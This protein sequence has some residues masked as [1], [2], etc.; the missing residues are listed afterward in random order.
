MGRIFSFRLVRNLG[1]GVLTFLIIAISSFSFFMLRRVNKTTSFIQDNQLPSLDA[2]L[3]A[4][5]EFVKIYPHFQKYVDDNI[6]E[7]DPIIKLID[8]CYEYWFTVELTLTPDEEAQL[9][10]FRKVLKQLKYVFKTNR[11]AVLYDPA[12][13]NAQELTELV[14]KKMDVAN[15]SLNILTDK[16][17]HRIKLS[18]NEIMLESEKNR[19]II[20]A[21]AVLA[22]IIGITI[23]ILINRSLAGPVKKLIEATQ[24]IGAGDLDWHIDQEENDEFGQLMGSFNVMTKK[25]V[26]ERT[27][28]LSD[29]NKNLNQE[30]AERKQ[31]EEK[32][33][34]AFSKLKQTQEDLYKAERLA[35][36]G[37]T[38]GRVAHEVLNPIT[39][40][41]SRVENNI[42]QWQGFKKN[43]DGTAE[44]VNDWHNEYRSGNFLEYLT[45]TNDDGKP[46]GDEDFELLNN[47]TNKAVTFQQQRK[48]DLEFIYKQ[49][50][51]VI[52]IIN[53]LREAARTQRTIAKF[54][55]GKTIDEA[56]EALEDSLKKRGIEFK[57]N[58]PPDLP[59]I[60]ADETEIIQVFTNMFRNSMQSI[61]EKKQR[62]GIISTIAKINN[63]NIEVRIQ[64]TGNG[65]PNEVQNSI[66]NFDFS[67][68]DKDKG[69]GLGLGISRRFVRESG[70]E[71]TLEES[72]EKIGTTFL[73][74]IPATKKTDKE[75]LIK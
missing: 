21:F 33:Q 9:K 54:N 51:R 69:T 65:I 7:Y 36:V 48:G 45:N 40:I 1:L 25:L 35:L 46:Y 72:T 34:S 13:S 61:D 15:V 57:K 11:D 29:I 58:I 6:D 17:Q 56:F 16:I 73:I 5:G 68:K 28:E 8:H 67:T 63:G 75:E 30:I 53:T 26:K 4:Q 24:R 22:M 64:D 52:K 49:L 41:Y 43:L 3:H 55:I 50:N 74:K 37:E 19:Q 12:S 32:L 20:I 31:A 23:I 44:I 60:E 18:S 2:V 39:S 66:F 10:R 70:G 38:S 47:L 59:T 27:A 14:T 62:G 71:M 42:K